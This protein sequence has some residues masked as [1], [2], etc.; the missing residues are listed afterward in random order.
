MNSDILNR[1][2]LYNENHQ[3]SSHEILNPSLKKNEEINIT[4]AYNQPLL[5]EQIE[6]NLIPSLQLIS[7]ASDGYSS[8]LKSYNTAIE[9]YQNSLEIYH[10]KIEAEIERE[11]T[12]QLKAD[13]AK[14]E[15]LKLEAEKKKK[16]EAE[17]Q[18]L[19][20]KQ[21]LERNERLQAS[22]R[23]M[24]SFARVQKEFEENEKRIQYIKSTIKDPVLQNGDLKKLLNKHK[25]LINPKFGQLTN[26]R[27][28]LMEISAKITE[29]VS[30]TKADSLAYSWILNF[31]AKSLSHQAEL[32]CR[33]KPEMAVPLAELT[34]VLNSHFPE[35]IFDYVVPRLVKKCPLIIGFL[36]G[37][38]K[39]M[40][41]KVSQD[42]TK[43]VYIERMD[44]ILAYYGML[45][46]LSNKNHVFI[47]SVWKM[48][49]RWANMDF[50]VMDSDLV[51]GSLVTILECCG[52]EL[53][54]KFGR[55]AEKL[56][57]VFLEGDFKN[58]FSASVNW[59]RLSIIVED[60]HAS[61][62]FKAYPGLTND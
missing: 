31:I 22:A 59:K 8:H 38:K 54:M 47:H 28:H 16:E 30:E 1:L 15:K 17:K 6:V 57:A 20:Q 44:G 52:N 12:E 34:H 40:G 2:F 46:K 58:E 55:Q 27:R 7:L 53:Y 42:E 19:I 9:E 18:D 37:D 51:L 60:K 35:L 14:V 43:A 32:E 24:Y 10:Q 5:P 41:F 23:F 3:P 50:R 61:G 4:N 11:R 21:E 33:V 26:S 25:R 29:L 49:T 56:I 62:S 13:E 48:V 36:C 45:C 39:K